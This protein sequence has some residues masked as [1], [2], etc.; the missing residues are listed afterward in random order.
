MRAMVADL[1]LYRRE[2][3][4]R[5]ESEIALSKQVEQTHSRLL[6]SKQ[7]EVEHKST[8]APSVQ[9]PKRD[10]ILNII[11]VKKLQDI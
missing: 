5:I 1:H 8:G 10:K 3:L 7:S 4:M 2:S 9:A 6:S 11:G